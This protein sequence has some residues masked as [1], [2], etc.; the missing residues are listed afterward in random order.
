M[1]RVAAAIATGQLARLEPR[2]AFAGL[3]DN[4][5][6]AV[7]DAPR[8]FTLRFGAYLAYPIDAGKELTL[9]YRILVAEGDVPERKELG[10]NYSAFVQAPVVKVER[11][12]ETDSPGR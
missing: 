4:A 1:V 6:V 11:I 10:R 5:R 12:V 8:P 9:R 7:A 3:A 2:G